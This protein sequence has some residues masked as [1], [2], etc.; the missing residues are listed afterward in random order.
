M[1]ISKM[2]SMSLWARQMLDDTRND[3]RYEHLRKLRQTGIKV[4]RE[5]VQ[6]WL[7]VQYVNRVLERMYVP[8]GDYRPVWE[9]VISHLRRKGHTPEEI[10]KIKD[11]VEM[12]FNKDEAAAVCRNST[13]LKQGS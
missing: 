1:S 6:Y 3:P 11:E 13:F 9:S 12:H 2:A 4:P 5:H 7:S 10:T 8:D